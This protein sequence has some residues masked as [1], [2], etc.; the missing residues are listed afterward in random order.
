[1][2]TMHMAPR[3]GRPKGSGVV[4][5]SAKTVYTLRAC[6]ALAAAYP[7]GLLK[8]DEIAGVSKAPVRF[9]S[10]ILGELRVAGL[11]S[12]RRGHHG[13]YALIRDPHDIL[14]RDVL[15]AVGAQEI[16]VPLPP[17]LGSPP[18]VFVDDLRRK[19]I[20]VALDAFDATTV[21]DLARDYQLGEGSDPIPDP[22]TD[23][24]PT[25]VVR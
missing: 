10:K 22:I 21:A 4:W 23:A 25:G 9:L 14:V 7:D 2:E 8:S 19:L 3:R 17:Q 20:Q 11:V 12:A 13:G 15:G 24:P 18:S 16:L 1:M 6:T 5:P